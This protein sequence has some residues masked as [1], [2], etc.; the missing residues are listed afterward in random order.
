M[1][2]RRF[3][4]ARVLA[5]VSCGNEGVPEEK[6]E[7][8]AKTYLVAKRMYLL[9]TK[10]G[11]YYLAFDKDEYFCNVRQDNPDDAS[12][13]A[14]DYGVRFVYEKANSS[15]K[16]D[17]FTVN[18]GPYRSVMEAARSLGQII[19]SVGAGEEVR[20]YQ[21]AKLVTM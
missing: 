15:E 20:F 16:D 6:Q 7:T 19:R 11:S 10:N 13:D 17:G 5:A 9:R 12:L 8:I 21:K 14:L 1:A 18:E 2:G 3:L 4:L